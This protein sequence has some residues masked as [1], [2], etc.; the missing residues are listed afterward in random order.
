[1]A[2]GGQCFGDAA[3]VC[4]EQL[5]GVCRAREEGDG[6]LLLIA[7]QE[8]GRSIQHVGLEGESDFA[9]LTVFVDVRRD[10]GGQFIK[11]RGKYF[12]W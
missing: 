6:D 2:S 5:L 3:L 10:G 1:M 9:Y 4:R 12:R 8:D 7:L 11:R